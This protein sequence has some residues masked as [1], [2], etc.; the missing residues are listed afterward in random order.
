ML[1]HLKFC[2][3]GDAKMIKPM[4]RAVHFD[5][6]TMPGIDNFGENFDAA[7][8]AQ[9]MADAH[10]EYVNMFAR[11]NI[12]FSYYPTRV[13]IPYP[14]MKGNMLGDV[15]RECHKRGIGVTGYINA[16]LNHEMSLRHPEWLQM[17]KDGQ[18]YNFGAGG[19]FFRTVCHNTGYFDHFVAE[20]KEVLE[21]GVD[22]LFCD[23]FLLRPCYCSSCMRDMLAAGID[24][25]DEA[26]VTDFSM[27]VRVRVME[28]VRKIVPKNIRL[29]FNGSRQWHG[30]NINSHYEVECLPACWGYDSFTVNAAAARPLY[31]EVIYMNGRF[32]A[33][34]GDFGG[35]KGTAAVENDFF[36]ALT[37][38]VTPMLGDHLHPA[39]IAER[40]VYRDLG[41][42]YENIIN[43]EKWTEKAKFIPEIAILTSDYSASFADEYCSAVRMLSE[44]KYSFDVIF[45]KSEADFT[46]YRVIILP[47]R[48]RVDEELAA[49]LDSYLKRGGKIISTGYSGLTPNGDGFALPQWSFDYLGEAPVKLDTTDL[50]DTG[51]PSY[52][53]LAYD[54]PELADMRYASYNTGIAMKAG[55]G[56]TSLAEEYNTYFDKL[57]WNGKHY[58]FYTPPKEAT[59]NSAMAVNKENNVAHISFSLFRTYYVSFGLVYKNMI[60]TLLERFMP[61]NLIKAESVPSTSRVT[62]TGNDDYKLLH[63]KV[64]YPEVRGN[65]GIVEEHTELNAGKVIAVRGEY[66]SVSLLPSETPVSSEIKDGYTY[67]T[68]PSIVG[69]DMFLLK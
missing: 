66:K 34:W 17:N 61:D 53:K 13:G 9:Q 27:S 62:L 29:F 65:L 32:Q 25:T 23:C 49:K 59:G 26:A 41:K 19:N 21:L 38:G 51:F 54:A 7:A 60:R 18:I 68:L 16:G 69:Y 8:F 48:V 52:F 33:S 67:I 14:G 56:N 50:F 11:C 44:L 57:G 5:F 47:D 37:Q 20:I 55:E 22:G 10:V 58:I 15:V 64:T 6:H 4:K 30:R 42:I 24:I 39:D 46:K 3:I 31:D 36:D 63:V 40:D 28:E 1:R 2:F 12:G 35:Y 43:Y 45:T